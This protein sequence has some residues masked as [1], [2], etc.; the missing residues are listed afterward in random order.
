MDKALPMPAL[1]PDPDRAQLLAAVTLSAH[2]AAAVDVVVTARRGSGRGAVTGQ[3][4]FKAGSRAGAGC[5]PEVA[6][7]RLRG[8]AG[9]RTGVGPG[10][11]GGS[12]FSS[13][14]GGVSQSPAWPG[15]WPAG[16]GLM[17]RR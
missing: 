14:G 10:R 15:R 9:G 11:G 16:P 8:G 13:P 2:E 4:D 17:P 3:E 6:G 12:W 1:S 5:H 7:G